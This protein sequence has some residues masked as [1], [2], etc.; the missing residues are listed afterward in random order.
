LPMWHRDATRDLDSAELTKPNLHT[1]PSWDQT[2][3][4][5]L[6]KATDLHI[7]RAVCG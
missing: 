2:G 7:A 6:F 4:E 3:F 5:E 1:Q